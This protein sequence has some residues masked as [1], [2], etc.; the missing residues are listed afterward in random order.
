M[1]AVVLVVL[2]ALLVGVIASWFRSDAEPARASEMESIEGVLVT[3]LIAGA[4]TRAQYLRAMEFLAARA[5]ERLP[6]DLTGR[7]GSGL[8]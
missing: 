5:G 7:P 2:V 8:A 4:I 1:V 6:P 3:K